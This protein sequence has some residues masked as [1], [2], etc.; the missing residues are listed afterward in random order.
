MAAPVYVRISTTSVD[1]TAL[2][3]G[4]LRP[5]SIRAHRPTWLSLPVRVVV[6]HQQTP[7]KR[8]GQA[9][10]GKNRCVAG[11]REYV[12]ALRLLETFPM[13]VVH[14]AVVDALKLGASS[15]DAVEHLALCRIERRPP[16]PSPDAY[17]YL[18]AATVETM[19]AASSMS[20]PAGAGAGAPT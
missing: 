6:A 8:F 2:P 13:V 5:P 4:R 16:K 9:L 17:P 1:A 18:P 10:S 14:G 7:P 20:R 11:K 12:Q 15:D 3:P 19:S